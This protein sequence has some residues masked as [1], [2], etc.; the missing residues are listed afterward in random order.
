MEQIEEKRLSVKCQEENKK[1]FNKIIRNMLKK[2]QKDNTLIKPAMWEFL[3]DFNTYFV[4][5]V[6]RRLVLSNE[7]T[8]LTN[9]L[10]VNA[11]ARLC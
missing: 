11:R 4:G 9:F 3:T 10:A 1:S 2:A 6:Y 8:N 5:G 7:Y